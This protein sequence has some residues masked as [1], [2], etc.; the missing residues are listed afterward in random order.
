MTGT[1]T[2]ENATGFSLPVVDDANVFVTASAKSISVI[3]TLRETTDTR[4]ALTNLSCKAFYDV[5]HSAQTAG[6]HS[7]DIDAAL[8]PKGIF[9]ASVRIGDAVLTRK[10][11]VN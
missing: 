3:Y 4:V 5:Q 1:F 2:A 9:L 10:F 11:I 7:A 8:L 6:T